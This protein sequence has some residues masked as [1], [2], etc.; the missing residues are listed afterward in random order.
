MSDQGTALG[1]MANQIPKERNP[2]TVL[3]L[4]SI[5]KHS[6]RENMIRIY[7]MVLPPQA[8]EKTKQL[9][10]KAIGIIGPR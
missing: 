3:W 8:F 4:F 7:Q 9:I 10:K 6:D 2:E 5:A 1:V